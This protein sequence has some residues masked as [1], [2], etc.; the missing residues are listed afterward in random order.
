MVYKDA[1][2]KGEA[3]ITDAEIAAAAAIAKSKISGT[4]TWA[5]S[6]I[7]GLP[8]SQITSGVLAAARGALGK[9]LSPS[10]L[11]D[12][13]LVY[14]TATDQF[15]M[16]AL[17]SPAAHGRESHLIT[18]IPRQATAD[19][20]S[21]AEGDLWY[22]DDLDRFVYAIDATTKRGLPWGTIDVDDHDA[23]HLV[24][25]ADALSVGIPASL[26][27]GASAAEGSGTNFCRRD[28]VHGVPVGTPS[29]IGT[30]NA[31]GSSTSLPRLD[32]VHAHPDLASDLHTVYLLASGARAMTGPLDLQNRTADPTLAEGR[33]WY[34]SDL[35]EL[36]MAIAADTKRKVAFSDYLSAEAVMFANGFMDTI[37]CVEMY[38]T[39]SSGYSIERE[40]TYA[41]IDTGAVANNQGCLSV[42]WMPSV[43]IGGVT[44][45]KTPQFEILLRLTSVAAMNLW[46]IWGGSSNTPESAT[47]KKFGIKVISGALYAFSGDG[48]GQSTLDLTTS[49][50]ADTWYRIRVKRTTTGVRVW[51]DG[52]EKTEKT[53]NVPAGSAQTNSFV[54]VVLQTTEAVAKRVYFRPMK[55]LH[56]Q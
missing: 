56:A 40:S 25:G 37:S 47:E 41:F 18:L 35:D 9:V 14:K 48:V 55:L 19:P 3:V 23:R 38:A 7:P 49:F 30:A 22:R 43:D 17:G 45:D 10:Y 39:G 27:A 4:G 31:A 21:F 54:Q 26:S 1:L 13:T 6:D 8:A 46:A 50:V 33:L 15:E 32:H 20:A 28:H 16:Q 11:N 29:N 51:V 42:K 53:T 52:T 12:Y 24:G 44:Y 5:V 2:L 36:W 34:R